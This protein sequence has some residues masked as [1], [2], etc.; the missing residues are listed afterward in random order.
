[1]SDED[2]LMPRI[3]VDKKAKE[4]VETD[5]EEAIEEVNEVEEIK[6]EIELPRIVKDLPVSRKK[7]DIFQGVD[8]EEDKQEIEKPKPV[9]KPRK[10]PSKQ[11]LEHLAKIRVSAQ[12]A[13][14]AK[15]LE[16]QQAIKEGKPISNVKPQKVKYIESKITDED[17]DRL[18]D[19][20]KTRRKAKKDAQKADDHA[21]KIVQSHYTPIEQPQPYKSFSDFF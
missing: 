20:Y 1:M 6:E 2:N 9:R 21:R 11:Q 18:I 10:P 16:R 19:R 12:M 14:K 5:E 13:K 8:E 15:Q 7:K 17:V 4:Y 3:V